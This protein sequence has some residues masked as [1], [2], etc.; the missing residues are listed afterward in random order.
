MNSI[1][2]GL[3]LKKM[4]RKKN[5]MNVCQC[6]ANCVDFIVKLVHTEP[7]GEYLKL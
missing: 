7:N 4:Y 6:H 2:I 1:L 5:N 3:K